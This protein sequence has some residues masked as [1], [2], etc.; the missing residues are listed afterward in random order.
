MGPTGMSAFT[1]AKFFFKFKNG[2]TSFF[3]QHEAEVILQILELDIDQRIA[4]IGVSDSELA[5]YLIEE[6]KKAKHLALELLSTR[7]KDRETDMTFTLSDFEFE[8]PDMG[9]V[10]F[11]DIKYMIKKDKL[12]IGELQLIINHFE[13]ENSCWYAPN[14]IKKLAK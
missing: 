8:F 6:K 13:S 9:F 7:W 4:L 12:S 3:E 14:G 1:S 11:K 2:K 10:R 5:E